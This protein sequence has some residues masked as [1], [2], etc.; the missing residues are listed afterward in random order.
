M[1]PAKAVLINQ[2]AF[3]AV[4]FQGVRHNISIQQLHNAQCTICSYTS[5]RNST[6]SSE[7]SACLAQGNFFVMGAVPSWP[8]VGVL[9]LAAGL[10]S[11]LMYEI[12]NFSAGLFEA[13]GAFWYWNV[14]SSVGFTAHRSIIFGGYNNLTDISMEMCEARLSWPVDRIMGGF[15]AGCA[16]HLEDST[17][18]HKIMLS[19]NA[20][21]GSFFVGNLTNVTINQTVCTP[22]ADWIVIFKIFWM[23]HKSI[24]HLTGNF[25]AETSRFTV[26]VS[27]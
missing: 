5:Y 9:T 1:L 25:G 17:F 26:C 21:N 15:R 18:W 6:T 16:M 4:Q 20:T 8:P 7:I 12:Q 3:L 2:L 14:N 27:S 13:N 24:N 23:T 11:G 22:N 10:P 19:C